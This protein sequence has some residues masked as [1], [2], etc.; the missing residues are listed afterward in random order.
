MGGPA[1]RAL[2]AIALAA[3]LIAPAPASAE[4][5]DNLVERT[6]TLSDAA[7]DNVPQLIPRTALVVAPQNPTPGSPVAL[8][9][10]GMH[11]NCIY[12]S[13]DGGDVTGIEYPCPGRTIPTW[14]GYRYLQRA[15]ADRGW[16]TMSVDPNAVNALTQDYP[17]HG[18]SARGQLVNSYLSQ[19]TAWTSAS[20]SPIPGVLERADL[21]SVLLVGHS[22]GGEGVN[23]AARTAIGWRARG[24]FNLAPTMDGMNPAPGM[25][26]VTLLGT[27][28]DDV[29]D[30]QGQLFVDG[31]VG[32][33][34]DRAMRSSVLVAHASHQAFNTVW[35]AE[36]WN[37]D[38]N[39]TCPQRQLS[40]SSQRQVALRYLLAAIDAFDGRTAQLIQ[41]PD[42]PTGVRTWWAG[43]GGPV[44]RL[45]GADDVASVNGRGALCRTVTATGR[46]CLH[47]YPRPGRAITP[48]WTYPQFTQAAPAPK[49]VRARGGVDLRFAEALKPTARR[50]MIRWM[51]LPGAAGRLR[52]R[53]WDT[54]GRTAQLGT[55]RLA[56]IPDRV[57]WAQPLVV[58]TRGLRD[59]A[60]VRIRQIGPPQLG[61]FWDISSYRPGAYPDPSPEPQAKVTVGL[62][63]VQ[64][65]AEDATQRATVD[66]RVVQRD[67]HPGPIRLWVQQPRMLPPTSAEALGDSGLAG[68]GRRVTIAR[69]QD[70]VSIDLTAPTGPGYL[71]GTRT[72][73][74]IVRPLSKVVVE[75]YAGGLLVLSDQGLP[76]ATVVPPRTIGAHPGDTLTW[77]LRL[78]Q[79]PSVDLVY[80]A[81]IR[82]PGMRVSD[83][84]AGW[85]RRHGGRLTP[86]SKDEPLQS[87]FDEQTGIVFRVPRG[88]QTYEVRLPTRKSMKTRTVR[89][90]LV[91]AESLDFRTHPVDSLSGLITLTARL[92]K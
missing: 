4:S 7:L 72:R 38:N 83:V 56:R 10:A 16:I 82:A 25:P 59:I 44:E 23:A 55:V 30:L 22:R 8:F 34:D 86:G 69:G 66:L 80:G 42:L 49:A 27:C 36:K 11:T 12:P 90:D 63:S 74:V 91:N 61:W 33:V 37:G 77:A 76:A 40:A 13:A 31:A 1:V 81:R 62:A 41:G 73:S 88:T 64:A 84:P 85:I 79:P 60:R 87:A 28:D 58:P 21:S 46:P 15:L 3:T 52:V 20:D 67:L 32:S 54:R 45:A 65:G 39:S 9:L 70:A 43:L 50:V 51:A 89:L 2:S 53:A 14:R 24:M 68:T 17:D 18:A 35:V 92:R 78:S 48:N 29:S 75:Q 57:L 6:I 26:S 5:R 19:W 47:G 71:G